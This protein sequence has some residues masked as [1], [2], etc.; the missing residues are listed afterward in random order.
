MITQHENLENLEEDLKL[1][2]LR[3]PNSRAH[4]PFLAGIWLTFKFGDP[5]PESGGASL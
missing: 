1:L 3:P 2:S 5:R 4:S